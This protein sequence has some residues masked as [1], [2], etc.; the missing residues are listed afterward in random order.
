MATSYLIDPA[1]RLGHVHYL[2]NNLETQ[3]TFYTEAL[4]LKLHWNTGHQ[5]GLGAGRED[6]LLLTEVSGAIRYPGST[7]MYHFALLVP[8]RK[9]LA[10]VIARLYQ[11]QIPH[12][13]TDHV[14]SKTTYLTD[15]DGNTIEI[16]VYS[17][18][19]GSFSYNGGTF[20]VR[21]ADGRPSTGREP[22]DLKKLFGELTPEDSIAEP[23][24]G[25]TSLGHV[26]LYGN[27]LPLQM[28][29]YRD[30]LGFRDGGLGEKIGMAEVA[31]DRPHVIAFNTW[32]GKSAQPPP[33]NSLGLKYFTIILPDA[34]G[35]DRV[36][37]RIKDH[38]ISYQ[39]SSQGIWIKDPSGILINLDSEENRR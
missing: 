10:R 35:L 2:T 32:Q 37:D 20:D 12:S 33:E 28:E 8:D 18:D 30:V 14:I 19:D 25:T 15:P 22:L 11:L 34:A 3:L 26:H 7:G 5:A 6:L 39:G 23:L 17:L 1:T 38:Q 13:P 16:Y 24:P 27:N 21:W 29:F 36:L 9:E 31:L 4:G